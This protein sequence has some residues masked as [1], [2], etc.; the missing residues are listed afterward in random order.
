MILSNYGIVCGK[1]AEIQCYATKDSVEIKIGRRLLK[2]SGPQAGL[3]VSNISHAVQEYIALNKEVF[4]AI[5]KDILECERPVC[6][7]KTQPLE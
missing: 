2:L 4:D 6:N 7:P 1:K 3:F 5:K